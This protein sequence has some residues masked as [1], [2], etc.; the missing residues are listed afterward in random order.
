M[1]QFPAHVPSLFNRG[2]AKLKMQDYVG[3]IS[4]FDA[5]IALEAKMADAWSERGVAKH[6]LG[7][8]QEALND[9][10]R[11]AELEPH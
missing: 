11:A 6:L 3:A 5:V 2:L 8:S 9:F 10:N 4:D 7:K 1:K